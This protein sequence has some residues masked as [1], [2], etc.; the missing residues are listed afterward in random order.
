MMKRRNCLICITMSYIQYFGFRF[1]RSVGLAD[2]ISARKFLE[3][4]QA[5][6]NPALFYSV[7]KF[8]EQRNV[9]LKG[10][11]NFAKGEL[12]QPFVD[13]FKM[14]FNDCNTEVSAKIYFK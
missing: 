3:A 8:F 9:R 2:Q 10:T 5:V 6:N 4:A 12:C 13:H 1:A 7:Y 14:L 11:P